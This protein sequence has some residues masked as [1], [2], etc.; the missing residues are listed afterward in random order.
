VTPLTS[1]SN[2]LQDDK[3]TIERE[4]E[5]LALMEAAIPNTDDTMSFSASENEEELAEARVSSPRYDQAKEPQQ[6]HLL[7][8]EQET[9]VPTKMES[10]NSVVAS[11]KYDSFRVEESNSPLPLSAEEIPG[12]EVLP[13]VS[14]RDVPDNIVTV[15]LP[16]EEDEDDDGNDDDPSRMLDKELD[17]LL[18]FSESRNKTN[19]APEAVRVETPTRNEST[20]SDAIV[21]PPPMFD[22]PA[23][24]PT[25]PKTEAPKRVVKRPAPPPPKPIPQTQ[26]TPTSPSPPLAQEAPTVSSVDSSPPPINGMDSDSLFQRSESPDLVTQ[27][28]ALAYSKSITSNT[29][30][31]G[32]AQTKPN[33]YQQ[34][35]N[36][37]PP[38][39]ARYPPKQTA[40]K[41]SSLPRNMHVSTG[42]GKQ[43][44]HHQDPSVKNPPQSLAFSSNELASNTE[45]ATPKMVEVLG[46]LKIQHVMKKRWTPKSSSAEPSP[47]QTPEHKQL[48]SRYQTDRSSTMPNLYNGFGHSTN[49]GV[50]QASVGISS[51]VMAKGIGA[52]LG[53]PGMG[54]QNQGGMK[55]Q[56]IPARGNPYQQNMSQ[57][58]QTWKSQEELAATSQNQQKSQLARQRMASTPDGTKDYRIQKSMSMPRGG[59]TANRSNTFTASRGGATADGYQVAYTTQA[60]NAHDLCSRCHQA[61]GQGTVLALPS[62]RTVYHV[63][64]FV[65]RVCRGSL[66]QGGKSTSV[67]IKNRQP[68]C[69]FCV[70]GDN[71][72]FQRDAINE[73]LIH[74]YCTLRYPDYGMLS[75]LSHPT[76]FTDSRH[77]PIL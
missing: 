33:P 50:G 52:G 34:P 10:E 47:V 66:S 40:Y 44:P 62:L 16:P 4:I 70:S 36:K 31:N 41:T 37:N 30:W 43:S 14:T 51:V 18:K 75:I 42:L 29:D 49:N 65:C 9:P 57:Q 61:L 26:A 15:S 55:F 46:D 28:Q 24:P 73:L 1:P 11:V 63:K 38:S 69:R 17:E 67:L 35:E 3:E 60:S 8:G 56:P 27:M 76:S 23:P 19:S 39:P 77:P 58:R 21:T 12:V 25:K 32:A 54:G 53:R 68:H 13:E 22:S 20:P 7:V 5:E 71:G 45:P 59:M 74:L 48:T 6:P 2:Q 64:C 72:K